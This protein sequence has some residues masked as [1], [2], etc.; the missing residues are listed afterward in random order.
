VTGVVLAVL[1]ESETVVD[2]GEPLVEVG[3]PADLEV[4]VDVLSRDAVQV[5]E[6]ARA[7]IEGW[8]GP[9]L[10][11]TVR[12]VE[13]TGFT[14]VSALGVEEQRVNIILDPAPAEDGALQ[15]GWQRLGHGYRV[16]VRITVLAAD[17]V[18]KVPL[19]ALFR[20]GDDWAVFVVVD[21]RAELRRI[22]IDARDRQD[23]M[24]TRGL[25]AGEQVVLYP[26]ERIGDGTPVVARDGRR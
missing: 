17:D 6:G 1:E 15:P 5:A 12:R 25:A 24:V 13:P 26:S 7:T 9:P 10:E 18:L 14:K 2:A 22:A 4:V 23:A 3:D 16:D 11:A 8:G 21:G 20:E 19:S